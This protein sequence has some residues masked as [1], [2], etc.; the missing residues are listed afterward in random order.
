VPTSYTLEHLPKRRALLYSNRNT[1]CYIQLPDKPDRPP[2]KKAL[3][4]HR[5]RKS[6]AKTSSKAKKAA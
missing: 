4:N 1:I 2:T 6:R 5:H 3:K